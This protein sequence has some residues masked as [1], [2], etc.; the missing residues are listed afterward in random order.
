M[1][2]RT[3]A[4]IGVIQS[5]HC[6]EHVSANTRPHQLCWQE[7]SLDYILWLRGA[8]PQHLLTVA[9]VPTINITALILLYCIFIKE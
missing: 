1:S 3:Q 8:V 9:D 2:A 5:Y 6:T 4:F 7:I